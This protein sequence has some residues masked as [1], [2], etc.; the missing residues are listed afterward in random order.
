[1]ARAIEAIYRDLDYA[2]AIIKPPSDPSGRVRKLSLRSNKSSGSPSRH[3]SAGPGSRRGG[4][5][6]RSLSLGASD[7]GHYSDGSWSVVSGSGRPSPQH[8]SLVVTDGEHTDDDS[9]S[10]RRLSLA[11]GLGS[12][13]GHLLPQKLAHELSKSERAP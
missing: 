5:H 10:G 3:S 11:S 4:S 9:D 8:R 1:M 12:I 6:S 7:C 2:K 13:V